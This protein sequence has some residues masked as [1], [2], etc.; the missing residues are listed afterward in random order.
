[1]CLAGQPPAAPVTAAGAVAMAACGPGVAG[2][3]GCDGAVGGGAG[4]VLAERAHD[5]LEEAC[6]RLIG[7]GCLP[8]RAGQPTQIVVHASLDQLRGLPGAAAAEAAWGPP[9]APGAE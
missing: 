3:G 2:G 8:D 5:A 1:M 6:R 7:A 9:A 4:G